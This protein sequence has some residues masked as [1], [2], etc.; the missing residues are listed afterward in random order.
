MLVKPLK[1]VTN[2]DKMCNK[3]NLNSKRDHYNA[4]FFNYIMEISSNPSN[5]SQCFIK[6][7]EYKINPSLSNYSHFEIL[8]ISISFH[9]LWPKFK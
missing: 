2:R 6:H 5:L 9:D 8:E 7:L 3:L 1:N 4:I